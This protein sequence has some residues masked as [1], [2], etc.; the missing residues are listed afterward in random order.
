MMIKLSKGRSPCSAVEWK[1][2]IVV[3]GGGDH[4]AGDVLSASQPLRNIPTCSSRSASAFSIALVDDRYLYV[5]FRKWSNGEELF[6]AD[7][8]QLDSMFS[9]A[10]NFLLGNFWERVTAMEGLQSCLI[11]YEGS[12]YAVGGFVNQTGNGW[13]ASTIEVA[14]PWIRKYDKASGCWIGLPDMIHARRD[15]AA[16]VVNNYLYAIGGKDS[17]DK[18]LASIERLDLSRPTS[19]WQEMAPMKSPRYSFGATVVNDSTLVVA[20]GLQKHNRLTRVECLDLSK[21]RPSWQSLPEL[22]AARSHCS[23]AVL[24]SSQL[25]LC[26]GYTGFGIIALDT[27]EALNILEFDAIP[28]SVPV[29]A[30]DAV[31]V[32]GEALEASA[33]YA[34]AAVLEVLPPDVQQ[35]KGHMMSQTTHRPVVA[36][37]PPAELDSSPSCGSEKDK[38]C[39]VCLD[40]PKQVAFLCG[41]QACLQCS[42]LLQECHTCRQPIQGRIQLF[43]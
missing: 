25:L 36:S 12:V 1:D 41:H 31:L 4:S 28:V 10:L 2:K 26:G 14:V 43:G 15:M 37:A 7:L 30:S 19:G 17:Q 20:G 22:T 24:Q 16:V 21:P 5:V 34:T 13:F 33:P 40:R 29:N 32:Q 11:A 8:N 38:S 18:A 23:L 42:P 39:A 3:I 35:Q 9:R 6:V 27:I